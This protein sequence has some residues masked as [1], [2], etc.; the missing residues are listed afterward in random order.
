MPFIIQEA[1]S[2][3]N[4]G[5]LLFFSLL[6]TPNF[7]IKLRISVSSFMSLGYHQKKM[8]TISTNYCNKDLTIHTGKNQRT[9][10]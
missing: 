8:T 7:L 5:I 10:V 4:D 6:Q 1:Q 9:G 2:V 3:I